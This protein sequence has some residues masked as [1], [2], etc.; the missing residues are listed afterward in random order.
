MAWRWHNSRPGP[1]AAQLAM[2]SRLRGALGSGRDSWWGLRSSMPSFLM[3]LAAA[4]AYMRY[5]GL[6]W[7][8]AVIL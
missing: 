1:L 8:Q 7:M 3:V 6:N 2:V 4:A 5:G